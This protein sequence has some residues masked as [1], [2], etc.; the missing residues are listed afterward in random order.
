MRSTACR[1][2]PSAIRTPNSCVRCDTEVAI[3]PVMPAIVTSSASA[4]NTV[5][6]TAVSFGVA[7]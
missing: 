7:R 4:A 6:S 3:T 5:S 2:A 1:L